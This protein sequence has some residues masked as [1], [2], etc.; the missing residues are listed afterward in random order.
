MKEKFDVRQQEE[1]FDNTC[2]WCDEE[3]SCEFE[4]AVHCS[5][6]CFKDNKDDHN[7]GGH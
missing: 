4:D 5:Q 6:K 7:T 1:T 3:F 2:D